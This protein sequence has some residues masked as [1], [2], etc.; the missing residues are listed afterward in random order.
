M[1]VAWMARPAPCTEVLQLGS[2]VAPSMCPV[3]KSRASH[4]TN[5]WK[6]VALCSSH[7]LPCCGLSS[8]FL[9]PRPH[10]REGGWASPLNKQMANQCE[11]VLKTNL[12]SRRRALGAL[13]WW[14]EDSWYLPSSSCIISFFLSLIF[15]PWSYLFFKWSWLIL[16]K[17]WGFILVQF[18][19]SLCDLSLSSALSPAKVTLNI[20]LPWQLLI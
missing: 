16:D 10:P 12:T 18:H 17:S 6:Q 4:H 19:L 14:R 11:K 1:K 20:L 13:Y 3:R 7:S 8:P 5:G 2:H 15:S 9:S